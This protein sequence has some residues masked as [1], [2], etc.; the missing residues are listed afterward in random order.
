MKE[1]KHMGMIRSETKKDLVRQIVKKP[2][3]EARTAIGE[4][5]RATSSKPEAKKK[6]MLE[7]LA[8][9]EKIIEEKKDNKNL[10]N[11]F[12]RTVKNIIKK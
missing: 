7:L 6:D 11:V 12:K 10:L 1:S 3:H 5:E 8:V 9:A 4:L 2:Y